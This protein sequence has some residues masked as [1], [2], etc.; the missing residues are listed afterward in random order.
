MSKTVLLVED[1][2]DI[3]KFISD[4]LSLDK[5]NVVSV[6]SGEEALKAIKKTNIDLVL[7]DILLPRISGLDVCRFIKADPE[8]SRI[9]VIFLTAFNV[10][11]IQTKCKNAGGDAVLIKPFNNSKLLAVIAKVFK[12]AS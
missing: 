4:A 7:L 2:P 9:P 5:Y 3:N 8:T 1:E 11:D 10:Q 12:E 6:S